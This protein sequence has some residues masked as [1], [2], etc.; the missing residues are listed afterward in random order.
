MP[1][2]GLDLLLCFAK[3]NNTGFYVKNKCAAYLILKLPKGG[4]NVMKEIDY[5]IN[6]PNFTHEYTNV[7]CEAPENQEYNAPH[8]FQVRNMATSEI[9][10][11]VHF[12]EG[13]IKEAGINGINNEDAILMVITRLES[14]QQS[15]YACSENEE[16]I[17]YLMRAINALRARTNRRKDAG[18]EGTSATDETEG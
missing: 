12:Q 14:F 7:Y 17:A 10:G 8:H 3:H 1:P 2:F 16:A 5:L 18:T 11:E 4:Y 9:V 13:P 15:E 6:R